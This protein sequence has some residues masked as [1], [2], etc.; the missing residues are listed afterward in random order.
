MTSLAG[1]I[2][3]TL[4][5]RELCRPG[6][7]VVAAVSGGSD[8]VAMALL[9]AELASAGHLDLAGI[10]HFDHG[11][12]G[13]LS[14][15]D[16][17]FVSAFAAGLGVPFRIGHADVGAIAAGRGRSLEEAAR[18]A[19]YAFLEDAR[20]ACQA[21]VIAVGHTRDDQAETILMQLSRG[22]GTRGLSGIHPRRGRVM[23]PAVDLRRSEL[24]SYLQ[25]RGQPWV[26]DETNSDRRRRRN[27]LRHDVMPALVAAEGD[28]VVDA[29]ARA[30][31]I[32]AA[33]DALLESMAADLIARA[34]LETG[35]PLRLDSR[36]LAGEPAALVRRVLQQALTGMTGRRPPF[37][38][39]EAVR[40]LLADGPPGRLGVSGG[41]VELSAGL[42]VLFNRAPADRAV[43]L[44]GAWR[45][46]LAIPGEL[47]VPEAGLRLR[48]DFGD[49]PASRSPRLPTEAR[50]DRARVGNR[51]VVRGWQPG[52]R[53]RL[54]GGSGRKKVQDLFVDRKVP[55]A[56]RHRVPIVTAPDGRIVWVAGHLIAGGFAANPSTK[57]VVVLNF[58]PLG[59]R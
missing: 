41:E 7:R 13:D 58:E 36:L 5:R 27:R 9:L 37:E 17:S 22:C 18:E 39:V 2:L 46:D 31:D 52:D 47:T 6:A 49:P 51:L 25:G 23:R 42:G 34:T 56:E 15:R 57:S 16:A 48:A 14:F 53:V 43:A 8:S 20:V 45:Y 30:A 59:G 12:R 32:A 10:A 54:P 4:R 3:A 44:F 55:R 33:D 29:I 26:D 21:D 1:R 24:A 50:L 40:R 19:R 11:L 28:G 38:Q 35:P